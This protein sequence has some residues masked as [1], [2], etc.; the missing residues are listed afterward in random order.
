MRKFS[1]GQKVQI[2]GTLIRVRIVDYFE[3]SDTK[4]YVR[5]IDRLEPKQKQ[6][7]EP[8]QVYLESQLE[9]PTESKVINSVLSFRERLNNWIESW[10]E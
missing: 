8:I 9:L 3:Q 1:V 2:K 10:F 4:Y 6:N 5:L 7:S